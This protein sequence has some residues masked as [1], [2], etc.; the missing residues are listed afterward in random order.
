MNNYTKLII[1]AVI[2]LLGF[3]IAIIILSWPFLTG[4]T[5]VLATIQPIGPFDIIM[6]QYA[7]INYEIN[8][9][10]NIS[11]ITG[12][13]SGKVIYVILEKDSSGI[14]HPISVSLSKPENKELIKGKIEYAYGNSARV[15]YGIE[16]FFFERGASFSM[17]NI[18]VEVKVSSSGKARISKLLQNGK[19]LDIKYREFSIA[20]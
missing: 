3:S 15:E 18:T 20:S 7:T 2:F 1:F 11:G 13:D 12:N 4:K 16:Q 14:S 17:R 5:Y 9:L 8:R 19:S 6:G 10:S